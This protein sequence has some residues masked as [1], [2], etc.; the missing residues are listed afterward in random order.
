MILLPNRVYDSL[1][2]ADGGMITILSSK[3]NLFKALQFEVLLPSG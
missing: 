3:S 1:F 2:L